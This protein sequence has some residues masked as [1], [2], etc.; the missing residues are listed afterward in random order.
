MTGP[1]VAIKPRNTGL[2]IFAGAMAVVFSGH[3]TVIPAQAWIQRDQLV[4]VARISTGIAAKIAM[5]RCW[6]PACAGMTVTGD[7]A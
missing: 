4:V 5:H 3:V 7:G 1:F 2:R 6:I